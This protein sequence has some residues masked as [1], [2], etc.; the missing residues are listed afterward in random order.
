MWKTLTIQN[1]NLCHWNM[2]DPSWDRLSSTQ[3]QW[4]SS[5]GLLRMFTSVREGLFGLLLFS[6]LKFNLFNWPTLNPNCVDQLRY[7]RP[8]CI[9]LNICYNLFVIY[10][11]LFCFVVRIPSSIFSIKSFIILILPKTSYNSFLS[12]QP[13][14]LWR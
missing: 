10:L 3:R 11:L 9:L 1:P 5:S 12:L 6:P 13:Y 4:W 14:S 8:F 2:V 7:L